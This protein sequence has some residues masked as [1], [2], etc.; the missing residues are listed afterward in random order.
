MATR[1]EILARLDADDPAGAAQ[2]AREMLAVSPQD[3]DVLG[4]LGLALE[5]GGDKEGGADA[6]RRAVALPADPSIA[7]R[8]TTNLA[9]M[10]V[11]AGLKAEAGAL[12]Q[13]GWQWPREAA[14][15]DNERRCIV[16]LA[17]IMRILDLEQKL[18]ELL[19]PIAEREPAR[20]DIQ[21]RAALAL[22]AVGRHEDAL[23]LL[24]ASTVSEA[25][26][27][28]R[29]AILA[30]VHIQLGHT[31]KAVAAHEAYKSHTPPYVAPGKADQWFTIGVLNPPPMGEMLLAPERGRHFNSNYPAQLL[32][33]L[34]GRYRFASVLL[35]AGPSAI[36]KFREQGPSVLIN[37][38]INAEILLDGST[39]AAV[40]TLAGAIQA[41]VINPPD[42]AALCTRQMN[43]ERFANSAEVVAPRLKRFN[44][45]AGRLEEVIRLAEEAF[46]YPVIVRTVMDHAAANVFFVTDRPSLQEALSQLNQPQIYVIQ[47]VGTP[48][49]RGYYRKMRAAFVEGVP[50]VV[51]ADYQGDWLVKGRE[52]EYKQEFYRNHPDLMSDANDIVSRPHARLGAAAMTALEKIGRAVPLDIFGLDFDVDDGGRIV[53]FEAN[54]TM[55]L[56]STA[57]AEFDYPRSADATLLEYVEALLKRRAA[58][59]TAP[60]RNGASQD[61]ASTK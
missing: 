42:R 31:E 26:D 19:V 61:R 60:L 13:G 47:Y 4:L 38:V 8:N 10:L 9:A 45:H 53:F 59:A 28:D 1:G 22:I 54:A 25:E 17:D 3:A 14:V 6:L 16:L 33:R 55:N 48:R 56:F 5:A 35:G 27:P 46:T 21:K 15:G 7:L 12:L 2:V 30:Y 23:R 57:P 49:W 51:R 36:E 50:L 40:Q 18:V 32:N 41:P 20:W 34:A 37:N 44:L 43:F 52:R 11:R 58:L 24:E 29:Q 39:L